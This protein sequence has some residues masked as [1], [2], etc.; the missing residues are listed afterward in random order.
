[1]IR[2]LKL[3]HWLLMVIAL[4]LLVF[5]NPLHHS[6]AQDGGTTFPITITDATGNEVTIESIDAIASGSGDVTEIIAALGFE[7]NLV[8]IDISS[9]YPEDLLDRIPE[10]GFA[11]RLAVEPIAAVNPTVFF[12]TETCSPASVFDQLRALNI[13]V[14]IIPDNSESGIELPLEK[15]TM[16]AAALGVPEEGE[17]LRTQVA[18]EIEWA[19]TAVANVTEEPTILFLYVRGRTLQLVSGTNTPAYDLI[20]T[21]DGIDVGA[22]AGVVGYMPLSAEVM[23][24][25][26]PE[27]IVMFQGSVDSAGGLDKVRELPGVGDTPAA[28]N[29]HILVFDDQFILGMSTRTGL[30]ALALAAQVHPTMTWE[31]DMPYPYH[32]TD[33][34]GIEVLVATPVELYATDETLLTTVQELGFH[35]KILDTP[36]EGSL[37]IATQSADWASLREAGYT[38][39]VVSDTA[40]IPEIA[41]ALGVPGRGEALIARKAA[42]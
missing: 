1:M 37:I 28:Q 7:D 17:A 24:N 14:V 41:A 5:T 18:R 23:L 36:V 8:G 38:V 9:T 16:V 19:K 30:A 33:M 27:Y 13:P 29:D 22:A 3:R 21:V 4:S 25:A 39:V 2:Q 34:T 32:Y 40:D 11:R 10:I 31:M 26:Y 12:C 20:G 6:Q 15:I 42:N 35:A